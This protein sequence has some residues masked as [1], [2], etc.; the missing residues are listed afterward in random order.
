MKQGMSFM[1]EAETTA[2]YNRCKVA[3]PICT[4]LEA[5]RTWTWTPEPK[6]TPVVTPGN[7][8]AQGLTMDTMVPLAQML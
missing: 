1:S 3:V 2:L 4:M 5:R 8:A 7:I 6:P